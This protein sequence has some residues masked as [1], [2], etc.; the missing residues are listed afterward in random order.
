[1]EAL[2]MRVGLGYDL[3]RLG[4]ERRLVLAGVEVPYP[5]GMVAHSDGD[6]VLHAVADA[7]LGALGLPDLG[8][9]FPDTDPTWK[10]ADSRDL[11]QTVLSDVNQAGY[12]PG[13]LDLIVHAEKPKL[14]EHKPAMQASLAQLLGL[15]TDQV[16]IKAKTNEG[17]GPV[18]K[19]DAIACTAIISLFKKT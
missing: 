14:S 10:D 9:R 18:G 13:N 6:V 19:G 4:P 12:Q 15:P 7:L 8:E 2:P 11:L 16:G 17:L 3:H 5:L 1:M